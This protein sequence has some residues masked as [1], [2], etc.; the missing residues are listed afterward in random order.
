MSLLTIPQPQWRT[1]SSNHVQTPGTLVASMTEGGANTERLLRTVASAAACQTIY[2]TIIIG[3]GILVLLGSVRELS[4]TEYGL[5][6]LILAALT[7]VGGFARLRLPNV[8]ASFS[9]SDSFTIAAA[10]WFGPAAGALT[11]A[12]DSLTMSV[13]LAR[14]KFVLRRLLFNATAPP[15]AMWVAAHGFFV[16]AGVDPLAEAGLSLP[17]LILPLTIF[18][19]LYFVL[20]TGLIAGAIALERRTALMDIWR[21]HFMPLWLSYF[22][23]AAIAA[24]LIALVSFGPSHLIAF[25]LIAPIPFILYAAFKHAT[26]RIEDRFAHLEHVNRMH[27]ATVEALATAIEAKDGVTHDHV[28]RVQQL[29]VQLAEAMGVT[30]AATIKAI[31]AAALLHDTG[32]IAVPEHILNKPGKLTPAEFEKMK[33]HVDVGADILSAIDFPYPVVPIVQCHHEAWD[34]S[35]YPRGLKGTAIP[36]GARVLSVV[37]CFD[38]LTSDRPYRRALTE[39]AAFDVLI[40]QRGK[41]YDPE[42]VDTF[43]RL[44]AQSATCGSPDSQ[45]DRG[46]GDERT[47]VAGTTNAHRDVGTV[48]APATA[49]TPV[50]SDDLRDVVALVSAVIRSI[51]HATCALYR[52]TNES[53]LVVQCAVGRLAPALQGV[54]LNV[55]AGLT[56]WVAANRDMI[57]N[58]DAALD[59]EVVGV[60]HTR[61]MCMSTPLLHGDELIGVLTV[62]TESCLPIPEEDVLALQKIAPHV[63]ALASRIRLAEVPVPSG[64]GARIGASPQ[65]SQHMLVIARSR[66]TRARCVESSD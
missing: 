52:P 56:G 17:A 45:I 26:G 60:R 30:D 65:G 51:P 22:G 47:S 13:Q 41:L 44:R 53:T 35:G 48:R 21:C 54:S 32:K 9:V 40:A 19:A 10:L 15:L 16:L 49:T 34:G 6:W 37:D 58:S 12:I 14:R 46:T 61:G 64:V 29:A 4:A 2:L 33:R 62:Y 20:N 24:L 57:V 55:N 59:L 8:P 28:R 18:V 1:Q 31:E 5:R 39:E 43:A 38:A 23:G 42:A 11:V 50:Q 36:I 27:L 25:A 3:S 66:T 7:M 63:A